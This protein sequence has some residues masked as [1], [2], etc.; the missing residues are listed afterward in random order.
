MSD[1]QVIVSN[2]GAVHTGRNKRAAM[3]EFLAWCEQSSE[4]NSRASHESVTL[5]RDGEPMRESRGFDCEL[6][7]TYGGEANYCWVN[8][9]TLTLPLDYSDARVM[10]AAKRAA[11][12]SN[13]PG[14]SMSYGDMLEYRPRGQ[15]VVLFV[16]SA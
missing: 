5:M 9:F 11:G 15:C 12:Y 3:R 6:T 1:Y 16:N 13:V 2:L 10:R 7:D 8:R 14:S 4:D